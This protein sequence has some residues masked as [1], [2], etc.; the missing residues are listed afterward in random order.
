MAAVELPV[1][2]LGSEIGDG[3]WFWAAGRPRFPRRL[4]P[5]FGLQRLPADRAMAVL[6][7]D[8]W[9]SVSG[10]PSPVIF[11]IQSLPLPRKLALCFQ[12]ENRLRTAGRR[13][14]PELGEVPVKARRSGMLRVNRETP[15]PFPVVLFHINSYRSFKIPF[16]K[17]KSQKSRGL[18][19][20]EYGGCGN[21]KI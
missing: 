5:A 21:R 17:S 8:R 13:S 7:E 9:S 6:S 3:T 2:A 20:S 19:S 14:S 18:T 11:G 1:E 12:T 16:N 4:P 15:H 10:Q